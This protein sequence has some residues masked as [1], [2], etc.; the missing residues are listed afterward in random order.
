MNRQL[1]LNFTPLKI[2]GEYVV[3]QVMD[4]VD[5]AQMT[6]LRAKHVGEFA[7]A[8]RGEK[9]F[10]LPLRHNVSKLGVEVKA[11]VSNNISLLRPLLEQRLISIF[12]EKGRLVRY[13][14]PISVVGKPIPIGVEKLD[15]ILCIRACVQ[16]S[17]RSFSV[18][19][20]NNF[21][22][23]WDRS[24]EKSIF[25]SLAELHSEG[26]N[27]ADLVVE[28]EMDS[29]DSRY[30]KSRRVVG[31]ISIVNGSDV[32][33]GERKKDCPE[34]FP[35]NSVYLEASPQNV[36]R[37]IAHCCG[38]QALKVG[39]TIDELTLRE[40]QGAH[41]LE[42]LKKVLS[43]IATIGNIE[44]QPNLSVS[45]GELI[46]EAGNTPF[47]NFKIV[48]PATYIFDSS[49]V[50]SEAKASAGLLRHGPYSRNV[51]T[52]SRPEICVICDKGRRGQTEVFLRKFK[53]GLKSGGGFEPFEKGFL[54]IYGLQD[55]LFTVF[56]AATFGADSYFEAASAAIRSRAESTPWALA[57]VQTERESKQLPAKDNPY[58]VAKAAFLANQIPTQ[59]VAIETFE[60]ALGSL[61]Y[62][63]SNL[64]LATYAKL[65]G[66]PW[67]IK[68]DT[69]IAHEVVLGIG[70][71]SI[72][73]SRF[74]PRERIVGITS[75]FRGDGGYL[76]SNVSQAVPFDKYQAA[77]ATSLQA[78]LNKVRSEMNW[79]SGDSIRV[80]VHAFK[81]MKDAEVNAV[82][83]ALAGVQDFDVKFAFVHVKQDHP[84]LLFDTASEGKNGRGKAAAIRGLFSELGQH[85]ALLTLVGPS[86]LK[87]P[88]DGLPKPVL[89]TLH[90]DSTFTD[91]VYLTK[92][93]YWF[94][95][96]SWRSFLPA[97]MPVT[98]LYSELIAGLLG[99]LE[100]LGN[101][102]SSTVMLG[103]IGTTRW[104]L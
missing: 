95:S 37:V 11:L 102:W 30:I 49:S 91:L 68:S 62:T 34:Q 28:S 89:L 77:L 15:K 96:H 40:G 3:Y 13:H 23:L 33:F 59:S 65:G 103:K 41:K 2:E 90:R 52:P 97:S 70:S 42:E 56:E 66:V 7:F 16:I 53:D 10:A 94:S 61:T 60:M 45:L 80:I 79:L 83:T 88:T 76:L 1:L 58:L 51:F 29:E 75:V 8:R 27:P 82:K 73:E 26:F 50:K 46:S 25:S 74:T 93:V 19:G 21:G 78:T 104:F 22:L 20:K 18:S 99:R 9:I 85:D 63:L 71:A 69:G 72:G 81:P 84:W 24:I 101:R 92:Q 6:G 86:E 44:L 4:F 87:R 55:A 64:A 98:I 36:R 48:P 12:A 39:K 17:I 14:S 32:I 31:R 5:R 57:I 54:R 100:Q 38:S 47:P 35:I 43:W 67:L